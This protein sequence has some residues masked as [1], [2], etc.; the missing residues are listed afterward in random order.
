MIRK[1]HRSAQVCVISTPVS[2]RNFGRIR[3]KGMKNNPDRDADWNVA[4]TP[5]PM[6]WVIILLMIVKALKGKIDA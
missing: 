1:V 2:P 3:I 5:F 4:L 6:D